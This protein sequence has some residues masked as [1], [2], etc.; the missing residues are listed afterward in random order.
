MVSKFRNSNLSIST[1]AMDL[2]TMVN[3]A[4]RAMRQW[5]HTGVFFN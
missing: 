4:L 3:S 2:A 1:G 5:L